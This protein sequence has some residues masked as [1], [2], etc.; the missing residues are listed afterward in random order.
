MFLIALCIAASS[1]ALVGTAVAATVDRSPIIVL[2]QAGTG[3]GPGTGTGLDTGKSG[4]GRET[5]VQRG[6]LGQKS[7]FGADQPRSGDFSPNSSSSTTNPPN[8]ADTVDKTAGSN[9]PS[10]I[11]EKGTGQ[12]RSTT[13]RSGGPQPSASESMAKSA[14]EHGEGKTEQAAKDLTSQEDDGP[15]DRDSGKKEPGGDDQPLQHRSISPSHLGPQGGSTADSGKAK[16][17]Q[18]AQAE[19][20]AAKSGIRH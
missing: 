3:A 15:S 2:V 6:T 12:M 1:S 18:A 9:F 17:D 20:E 11:G 4:M 13:D 8:P 19:R 16:H 7:P 5:D 14:H 10:G